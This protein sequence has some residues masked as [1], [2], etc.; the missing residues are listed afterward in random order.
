MKPRRCWQPAFGCRVSRSAFRVSGFGCPVSVF[1]FGIL[2]FRVSGFSFL[3]SSFE[4]R[5]SRFGYRVSGVGCR[6][7]VLGFRVWG[8]GCGVSGF[9]CWLPTPTSVAPPRLKFRPA[10][11]PAI[12]AGSN[13]LFRSP[14]CVSQVAGFRQAPEHII[15][16]KKKYLILLW[17]LVEC[18]KLQALGHSEGGRVSQPRE[19]EEKCFSTPRELFS[20]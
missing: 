9:G 8:V 1:W 13:R 14:A 6:V 16:L 18:E 2:E 5:V 17:G 3:L 19:M 7:S 4:F 10:E 15:D 11:P 20:Y 12:N